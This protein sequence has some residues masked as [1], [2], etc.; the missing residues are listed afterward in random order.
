M[1]F[2]HQA[3]PDSF[4]L[5]RQFAILAAEHGTQVHCRER[6]KPAQQLLGKHDFRKHVCTGNDLPVTEVV[7][8]TFSCRG[9]TYPEE[10]LF[11]NGQ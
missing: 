8:P 5:T 3:G 4:T 6:V 1:D 11:V 9:A 7:K 2:H 10:L